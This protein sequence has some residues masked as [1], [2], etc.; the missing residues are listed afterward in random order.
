MIHFNSTTFVVCLQIQIVSVHKISSYILLESK[1]SFV[2]VSQFELGQHFQTEYARGYSNLNTISSEKNVLES[3]IKSYEKRSNDF[4]CSKHI[5]CLLVCASLLMVFRFWHLNGWNDT[6]NL[7]FWL[8][9]QHMY[10]SLIWRNKCKKKHW[11]EIRWLLLLIEHRLAF[12]S[13]LVVIFQFDI[14]PCVRNR[15]TNISTIWSYND[16]NA[17]MV[18]ELTWEF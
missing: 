11:T 13:E 14:L 2:Y 17:F 6:Y 3:P 1:K 9:Y 16:C 5:L 7:T 12:Q 10:C 15:T 18:T 8:H 4:T